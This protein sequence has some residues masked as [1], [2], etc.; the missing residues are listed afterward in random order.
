MFPI[1]A[2]CTSLND[3]SKGILPNTPPT[4][5]QLRILRD[6]GCA[7]MGGALP[8]WQSAGMFECAASSSII[9]FLGVLTMTVEGVMELI[10]GVSKDKIG[11]ELV[12]STLFRS[13][14]VRVALD[15]KHCDAASDS[16]PHC[17]LSPAGS[18]TL[19]QVAP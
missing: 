18:A 15:A 6:M 12:D 7:R 19:L 13:K 8:N 10:P 16:N 14:T 11:K 4:K 1:E 5:V 9:I 3:T 17:I 2:Y